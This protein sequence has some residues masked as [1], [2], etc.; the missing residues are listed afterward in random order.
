MLKDYKEPRRISE[1]KQEARDSVFILIILAVAFC[2]GYTMKWYFELPTV[3][4]S[5]ATDSCYEVVDQ[6]GVRIPK[7]CKDLPN[8]YHKEYIP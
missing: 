4:I 6:Y 7:G 1:G 5:L 2:F 3:R 8:K